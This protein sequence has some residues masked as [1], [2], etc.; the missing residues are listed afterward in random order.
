MRN[1]T[2]TRHKSFVGCLGKLKVYIEDVTQGETEINGVPCRFLGKIRNG[3]TATFEISGN[4]ARVF[5]IADKLTK[6]FC[7]DFAPIPSGSA[8]VS[9]SGKCRFNPAAGNAFRFD[10][11]LSPEVSAMRRKGVKKGI[12]VLAVALIVGFIAGFTVTKLAT[13]DENEEKVYTP[14]EFSADGMK[15][16]LNDSFTEKDFDR[17]TAA[18][19]SESAAVFVTKEAFADYP[20]AA[21]WSVE[22]YGSAVMSA[23]GVSGTALVAD[24]DLR[25]FDYEKKAEN[26]MVNKFRSFVFKGKDAFW[27]VQFAC[28][29]A[30]AADLSGDIFDWARSVAFTESK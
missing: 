19:T 11:A 28:P 27:L 12:V 22:E 16:T 24:G 5:V 17:F 4:A 25:Y 15:I 20:D 3:E 21:G 8:D 13:S 29:S 6:N 10:G 30:K 1:L 9:L 14:K 23:N 18:F 7:S 26:G 2:I